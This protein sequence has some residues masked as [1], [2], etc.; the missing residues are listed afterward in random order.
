MKVAIKKRK[1]SFIDELILYCKKNNINFK[2]VNE[3]SNSILVELEGCDYFLWHW[4]LTDYKAPIFIKQ[5]TISL[6]LKGVNDDWNWNK[7]VR[8]T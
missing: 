5:L 2:L 7:Y 6:E 1:G 4:V 3:Y 8:L